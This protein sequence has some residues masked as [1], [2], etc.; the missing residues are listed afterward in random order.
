MLLELLEMEVDEELLVESLRHEGK[1]DD[2][3]IWEIRKR[4]SRKKDQE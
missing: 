3:I 2:W 1:E 4:E